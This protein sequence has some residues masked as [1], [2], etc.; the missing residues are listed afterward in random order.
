[1]FMFIFEFSPL[2][3]KFF[4]HLKKSTR[5]CHVA[6]DGSEKMILLFLVTKLGIS[7]GG[8]DKSNATCMDSFEIKIWGLFIKL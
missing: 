6:L 3:R 1:M 5:T 2:Y 7:R 8:V 4:D